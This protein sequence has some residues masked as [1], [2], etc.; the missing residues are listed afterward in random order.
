MTLTDGQIQCTCSGPRAVLSPG[1]FNSPNSPALA[2]SFP[3][4]GREEETEA[5]SHPKAEAGEELGEET[6]RGIQEPGDLQRQALGQQDFKS[7]DA[8]TCLGSLSSLT[9]F[10]LK[11]VE[12]VLTGKGAKPI[13]SKIL[14]SQ[15]T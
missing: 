3:V 8:G 1:S 7:T 10:Q 6:E 5:R 2:S 9:T 4:R 14:S 11:M 15:Q 12:L 13:P